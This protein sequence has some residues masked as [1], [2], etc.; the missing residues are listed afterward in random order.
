MLGLFW[1]FILHSDMTIQWR[2]LDGCQTARLPDFR[3][4]ESS[5][6]FLALPDLAVGGLTKQKPDCQIEIKYK[7]TQIVHSPKVADR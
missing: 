1:A 7:H 6:I 4:S 3:Q 2:D 5:N